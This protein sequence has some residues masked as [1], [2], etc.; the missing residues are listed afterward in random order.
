MKLQQQIVEDFGAIYT[1]PGELFARVPLNGQLSEDT[2][3][4]KLILTSVSHVLIAPQGSSDKVVYEAIIVDKEN[5]DYDGRGKE[6]IYICLSP[7]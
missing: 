6:Y 4:G 7:T 2:N 5:F 1:M 3:V